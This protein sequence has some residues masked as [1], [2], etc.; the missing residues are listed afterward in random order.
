MEPSWQIYVSLGKKVECG[1]VESFC[2]GAYT[3]ERGLHTL[4]DENP[5]GFVPDSLMRVGD[6]FDIGGFD[7]SC[8]TTTS[9]KACTLTTCTP[10]LIVVF[11]S[12]QEHRCS[13]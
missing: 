5:L 8:L 2:A 10:S 6:N 9:N 7:V 13:Y 1:H 4:F 12:C 11:L 3:F